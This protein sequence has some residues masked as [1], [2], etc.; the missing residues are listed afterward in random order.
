MTKTRKTM[1]GLLAV[2]ALAM[3]ATPALAS[4]SPATQGGNGAGKSGQCTGNPD[5]R[6]S[7]C[8]DQGGPGNQP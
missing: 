5:G 3:S 1:A 4:P 8:H 2:G 6:P 7:S